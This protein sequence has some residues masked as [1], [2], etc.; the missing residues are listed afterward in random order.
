MAFTPDFIGNVLL[1]DS[2]HGNDTTAEPDRQENPYLTIGAAL[3]AAPTTGSTVLVR[4]GNYPE[5][6]L[7]VNGNVSLI[8]EGGWQV[9]TI[10]PA[11]ASATSRFGLK[12]ALSTFPH[13][14]QEV[15]VSA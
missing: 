1:V 13:S 7:V 2:I 14:Y 10:G 12:T 6:G 11:P 9:T 4:P 3:A 8:G 5:E 15:S